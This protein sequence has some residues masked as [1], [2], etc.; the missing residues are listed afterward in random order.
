MSIDL[1]DLV[2][3]T[4]TDKPYERP[5][6]GAD[7]LI[8]AYMSQPSI[9]TRRAYLQDLRA[10]RRFIGGKD[11]REAVKTLLE[12]L[13]EEGNE[14]ADEYVRW[15]RSHGYTAATCHRRLMTLRSLVRA[16]RR[17]GLLYWTIDV[18]LPKPRPV[19]DT[20]GPGR[21]GFDRMLSS[22]AGRR[23][24]IS[25][26]DYAILRLLHD[27]ALRAGEVVSLRVIDVDLDGRRLAVLG[28]GDQERT[29]LEMP[30]E[31]A[32]AVHHWLAI[33]GP[34]A[35]PLFSS[36]RPGRP[37]DTLTYQGLRLV[38][39]RAAAVAGIRCTPHG[40]RHLATT[41]AIDKY[42]GDL[43]MVQRFTRHRT[44]EALVRYDDD[45]RDY[46]GQVASTVANETRIRCGAEHGK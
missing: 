31:T 13:P 39:R 23:D 10:F 25:H 43:R 41:T 17:L 4:P 35:G 2:A 26:R 9:H 37:A 32:D 7:R 29:W 46:A 20:R 19:R 27:M 15:L 18:R 21:G 16:A 8:R 5:R 24:P 33:R 22:V 40:L 11:E 36:Q 34:E 3:E 38:V 28:K 30:M 6:S 14:L 12:A 44:L 1:D 45:R 42:G